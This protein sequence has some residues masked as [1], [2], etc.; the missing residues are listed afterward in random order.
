MPYKHLS[1]VDVFNSKD[2]DGLDLLVEIPRMQ[3]DYAYGRVSEREKRE[4]FLKKIK[5][6]L[7]SKDLNHEL[8][9]VYGTVDRSKRRINRDCLIILDGQQRM[10]TLFLLHWYL[11]RICEKYDSFSDLM[12]DEK[13]SKFTYST[14]DSSAA[15]C[16]SLVLYGNSGNLKYIK[17]DNK[18][19]NTDSRQKKNEPLSKR[20]IDEKW[21]FNHW[22]S[23][24]TVFNMLIMID[25]IA[26]CFKPGECDDFY[27]KLNKHSEKS[28][29][30]FN[31]LPFEEYGLTDELYIKMNSRGKPLTRFENLKSKILK[32]YDNLKETSVYR[33]KLSKIRTN[34]EY[35][36]IESLR[37][38]VSLMF[39]T[40]WTDVFWNLWLENKKKDD[41]KPCVDE[42]MLSYICNYCIT[43]EI[44]RIAK[45]SYSIIR[46][47][48][49][50]TEIEELMGY[51]NNVPYEYLILMLIVDKKNPRLLKSFTDI[52]RNEIYAVAKT[53]ES[54]DSLLFDLI[55]I[56]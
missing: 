30:T 7:C 10:T 23:D 22:N 16:N 50:H 3:R 55:E 48:D 33:A 39:D 51:K 35:C 12:L 36:R 45:N 5:S 28:C 53:D 18:E 17:E 29:I 46:N 32:E 20:I 26:D 47:S 14:R 41:T 4:A 42:M 15:F 37:D 52:Q 27:D 21:F 6:Y 25:A 38:Y 43:N 31:F 24:P 19:D 49:E 34:P 40:K 54:Y 44:L 9:F 1:F 13:N 2:N 56:M 8:D 11:A